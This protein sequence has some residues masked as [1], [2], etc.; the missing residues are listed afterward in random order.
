MGANIR[1]IVALF[2]L[3][4]FVNV[5]SRSLAD[6][7]IQPA[8]VSTTAVQFR[9]ISNSIDQIGI[10]DILTGDP[11]PYISGVTD[12]GTYVPST[13][14]AGSGTQ[15]LSDLALPKLVTF[16]LGSM[17]PI[18]GFAVW[19][20]FGPL[21]NGIKDFELFADTDNNFTNGGTIALGNFTAAPVRDGQSFL[22]STTST[23]FV[24]L[25]ITSELGGVDVTVGD[26]AFSAVPEPSSFFFVGLIGLCAG[27]IRYWRKR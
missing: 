21:P 13:R 27:A 26:F 14:G 22:F 16:D 5:P 24:H 7:I 9:P 8:G 25:N 6:V 23:Q 10:V 3:A 18:N 4:G 1:N 20:D 15:W 12:F 17:W 11:A 2:A 19:L